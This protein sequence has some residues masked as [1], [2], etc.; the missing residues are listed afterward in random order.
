MFFEGIWKTP[1][2][3]Y[4]ININE[5]K[6]WLMKALCEMSPK[7]TDL[8][9]EDFIS[10]IKK[11]QWIK[12]DDQLLLENQNDHPF[13]RS[14]MGNIQDMY[15]HQYLQEEFEFTGDRDGETLT[16]R[17]KCCILLLTQMGKVFSRNDLNSFHLFAAFI[18]SKNPRTELEATFGGIVAENKSRIAQ[19][20]MAVT[21][22]F[23]E[24]RVP[25]G[26]RQELWVYSLP[27]IHW[28]GGQE[29]F[30]W[31]PKH[32][33]FLVDQDWDKMVNILKTDELLSYAFLRVVQHKACF[34][35]LIANDPVCRH[36][37][38]FSCHLI[39]RILMLTERVSPYIDKIDVDLAYNALLQLLEENIN[40]REP[41]QWYNM[42][43]EVMNEWNKTS[44]SSYLTMQLSRIL[45]RLMERF[46]ECR[47][48][49]CMLTF[50]TRMGFFIQRSRLQNESQARFVVDVLTTFEKH[51]QDYYNVCF[52]SFK[53][54]L[55]NC[56]PE[57]CLNCY[58]NHASEFPE[59]AAQLLLQKPRSLLANSTQKSSG[60]FVG[61]FQKGKD[62]LGINQQRN[63]SLVIES[64]VDQ[65]VDMDQDFEDAV[66]A[67]TSGPGLNN[68]IDLVQLI[69]EQ[70][71]KA[72]EKVKRVYEN[73]SMFF[74]AV[75]NGD[76]KVKTIRCFSSKERRL[77][78]LSNMCSNKG[79]YDTLVEFI[80]LRSKEI[81][82]CLEIEEMILKFVKKME[83]TLDVKLHFKTDHYND[84]NRKVND[85]CQPRD[86]QSQ[87]QYV[88]RKSDVNDNFLELINRFLQ[89]HATGKLFRKFQTEKFCIFKRDAK[90]EG[91]TDL[92]PLIEKVIEE[93][94]N[95]ATKLFASNVTVGIV[96]DK[97][98]QAQ[99]DKKELHDLA[100]IFKINV[101]DCEGLIQRIEGLFQMEKC[102]H[103]AQA[104]QSIKETFNGKV[105]LT[106]LKSVLHTQLDENLPLKEVVTN[107]ASFS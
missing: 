72:E 73:V 11:I 52:D 61:I 101:I 32:Q 79:Q 88:E 91:L 80:Q 92:Y 77:Q 85:L 6:L 46:E 34:D 2:T 67:Y 47:N 49:E 24:S 89:L 23:C 64:C 50:S 41:S 55:Q 43:V 97:F 105:D 16:D 98:R 20:I 106:P 81:T 36:S 57:D 103:G 59:E 22:R 29:H 27:L 78:C 56:E 82:Y 19:S 51:G 84:T 17:L 33:S 45:L 71:L 86:L 87:Q 107:E 28:F 70:Y 63:L 1:R 25:Y 26:T 90:I 102:I 53:M 35:K 13:R 95:F 93:F 54:L 37:N 10:I 42:M 21:E 58:V 38:E 69:D 60:F 18:K 30:A 40:A 83:S 31:L 96:K 9:R 62:F 5:R 76:V 68:V 4:E 65:I 100:T 7:R 8:R 66:V 104:L 3:S 12:G 99:I 48:D 74:D 75:K 94:G 14:Y 15:R 44:H 39:E